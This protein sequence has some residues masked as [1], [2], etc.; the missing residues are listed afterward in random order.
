VA[1]LRARH[2]R[3]CAL[4]GRET[5]APRGEREKIP[6]CT[7][8][9][10]YSIRGGGGQGYDRLGRDLRTALRALAKRQTDEDEGVYRAIENLRF[11]QWADRWLSQ[12]ER[13]KEGTVEGYRRTIDY[14]KDAFGTK[15]MR[16]VT[17][18]DV[19]GLLKTMREKKLSSSTQAQHLRVLGACF[20]SAV[21][22]GH[23]AQNPIDRLPDSER[24]RAERR[25]SAY[26]ADDELPRLLAEL[27]EGLWATL[28]RTALATGMREGELSALTWG[29]ADL[30]A[31]TIRV[32]R[33]YSAGRL[34]QTKGRLART[35]DLPT[36]TVALLGEWWGASG[37]PD[38]DVLMF[39]REDGGGHQ[40]FWRYTKATLYPAMARAGIP[41]E[42]PT[43]EERTFH[44]LRHTYAR[45][46]LEKGIPISW[47]SR[48]LGHSSES[49]TDQHYGHWSRARSSQEAKRLKGV[50]AL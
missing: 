2:A 13:P 41:R 49:V 20:R 35:V 12:L 5:A 4:A 19:A 22:H 33:T 50:F 29:D 39:P 46:V 18:G 40:P 10:V 1:S 36:E 25:E 32:R 34:G 38:D 48:Q 24:P 37:K 14:A 47:L 30:T 7:C 31:G 15:R 43:G 11:E 23:A 28:T 27:P 17:P 44:S 8:K 21:R 6:D 3:N 26:F 9:P 42:G 45:L 16:K